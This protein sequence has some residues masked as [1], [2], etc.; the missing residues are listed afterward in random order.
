MGV[1]PELED[2]LRTYTA[3]SSGA[4]GSP[5]RLDA[6]VWAL[7]ELMLSTSG[8]DAWIEHY[9]SLA[10]AA[11]EPKYDAEGDPLPW[12]NG[13]GSRSQ[14]NELTRLYQ[15]TLADSTRRIV[16]AS[17]NNCSQ[18]RQEIAPGVTVV[19]DGFQ[20]FHL[21]CRPN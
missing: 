3:G 16:D 14:G 6:L 13:L 8:A 1:Y 2:Q 18:C 10:R 9:A 17:P 11:P 4:A 21:E 7:S 19:S 20:S 15:Q 5:D 12:R